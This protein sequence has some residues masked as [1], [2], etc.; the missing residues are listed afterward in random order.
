VDLT[1][2]ITGEVKKQ[3]ECYLL[4]DILPEDRSLRERLQNKRLVGPFFI[5]CY[6]SF[7]VYPFISLLKESFYFAGV[8]ARAAEN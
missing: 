1:N 3:Q 6:F 8:G 2:S 5:F 4:S 7:Y